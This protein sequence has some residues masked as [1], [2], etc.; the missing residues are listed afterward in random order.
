M[1]TAQKTVTQSVIVGYKC[2]VCGKE[3]ERA[4]DWATMAHHHSQWGNDSCD[5]VENFDL[6]SPECYL[7]QLRS[8]AD[9]MSS[10][11]TAEIDDKPLAF[12]QRLIKWILS[13]EG[14][15]YQAGYEEGAHQARLNYE[16]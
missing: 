12:V 4:E 7:I 10:Y 6:C 2:D 3:S 14:P 16:P 9:E 5:S 15:G 8:S 1:S 13:P 11:Y